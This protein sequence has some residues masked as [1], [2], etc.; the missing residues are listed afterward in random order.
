MNTIP[1][2]CFALITF[3]A[4]TGLAFREYDLRVFDVLRDLTIALGRP[5][6]DRYRVRLSHALEQ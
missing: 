3:Y 5:N 1:V 2:P 4:I 6:A